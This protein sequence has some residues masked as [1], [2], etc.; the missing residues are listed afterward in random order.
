M[1]AHIEKMKRGMV[2]IALQELE[3]HESLY[4]VLQEEA[5]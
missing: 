3:L 4:K 5:Q 2:G 1:T